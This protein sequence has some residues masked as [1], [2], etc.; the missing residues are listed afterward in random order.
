MSVRLLHRLI[1]LDTAVL[2]WGISYHRIE[3]FNS[4]DIL[5]LKNE[6]HECISHFKDLEHPFFSKLIMK[7][8][9]ITMNHNLQL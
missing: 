3:L 6:G 2:H 8:M 7:Y 1:R 5:Y 9:S 4:L